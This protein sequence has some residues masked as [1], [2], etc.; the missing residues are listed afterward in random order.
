MSHSDQPLAPS[1]G[2]ALPRRRGR[3]AT[4]RLDSQL[5][6]ELRRLTACGARS[7]C[8]AVT[9]IKKHGGLP[10][11]PQ[12]TET[13]LK[14]A[15]R[16]AGLDGASRLDGALTEL[17][18]WC[19]VHILPVLVNEKA[20]WDMALLWEPFSRALFG[21]LRSKFDEDGDRFEKFIITS[22]T[23]LPRP[24]TDRINEIRLTLPRS[25]SG[26][27]HWYEA[28]TREI[29]LGRDNAS[30]GLSVTARG[31]TI[32]IIDEPETRRWEPVDLTRHLQG[33]SGLHAKQLLRIA[34]DAHNLR[35][36]SDRSPAT[37]VP[38]G[39]KAWLDESGPTFDANWS[40][41]IA[42]RLPPQ[43]RLVESLRAY[44]KEPDR[45]WENS[46]DIG[47]VM[48]YRAKD[49]SAARFWPRF[50]RLGRW[51]PDLPRD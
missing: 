42:S 17:P 18:G 51:R 1:A 35:H 15:L 10:F 20:P 24:L 21:D 31:R 13:S 39:L 23:K 14:R 50:P 47:V 32:P 25:D 8:Q 48:K 19:A 5:Y 16:V 7:M 49:P 12:P 44:K 40:Q 33:G 45:A 3:P 46:K 43:Q 30:G 36:P 26:F 37:K 9:R 29:P 11:L 2:A 34:L 41:K 4:A 28:T 27:V 22:L 38:W 6:M